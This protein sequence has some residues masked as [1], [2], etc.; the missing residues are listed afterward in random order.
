[1]TNQISQKKG[2]R[3]AVGMDLGCFFAGVGAHE[4]MHALGFGHM[5]NA[6]DRDDGL[7]IQWQNMNEEHFTAFDRYQPI[8]FSNF[9]TVKNEQKFKKKITIDFHKIQ[10]YDVMSCTNYN[11][12]S[13]TN[14]GQDVIIPRQ[15]QYLDIV[16]TT[17]FSAGDATRVNRMYLCRQH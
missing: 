6:W 7:E 3:Q 1:M 11:R 17:Q 4:V 16:G 13:F 15:R 14:N 10:P 2:G 8:W 12:Q 9:N 5:H